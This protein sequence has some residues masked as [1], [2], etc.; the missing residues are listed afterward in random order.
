M[1]VLHQTANSR[2]IGKQSDK[3]AIADFVGPFPRSLNS[4]EK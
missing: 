2:V 4:C 3:H 1:P